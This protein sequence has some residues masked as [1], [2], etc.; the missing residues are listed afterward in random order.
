[1]PRFLILPVALAICACSLVTQA[2]TVHDIQFTTDPAGNSPYAGQQVGT[3]GIVTGVDFTGQPIRY[4]VSDRGGGL[5]SGVL[6]N[7]NQDRQVEI[8]DSVSFT[9]EVQE[10]SGQTRLR[11]IVVGS[12]ALVPAQA[13]VPS[14]GVA[15]A[16]VAESTEGVLIELT[17]AVVVSANSDSTF[18]VT[19]GTGN[20]T[21]ARGWYSTYFPIVGDTLRFLRGIVSYANQFAVN[22]RSD[23]DLGFFGNR[24]PIILN[25]VNTPSD[26]TELQSDTVTAL[27]TD[28]GF[29]ADAHLHYR[30]GAGE[31]LDVELTDD[32]TRADRLAGDHVYSGVIPAGP[33]R[34]VCQYF[35]HATDNDA[36]ESYSP[37][38]AP[39]ITYSYRVR[40]A[41]LTIFDLQYT[42]D[43]TGGITPYDGQTVTV[44]GIVTGT[45][46]GS[47]ASDFF[48]SDPLSM[49]PDSGRWSGV[50]VYGAN[51]T[52]ALWDS[53]TI[54]GQ[55]VDYSGSLT[56]FTSGG[57]VT[58]LGTG[59]EIPPLRVRPAQLSPPNS[60]SPDS[61]EA[62]EGVLVEIGV[63]VVTNTDDYST[64]QQFDVSGPEGSCTIINDYGFEYTPIE[65]DSFRFIRGNVSF[66]PPASFLGHII[67]PRFDADLDYIDHRPPEV[68]GA[69]AVSD[70]GVN[71]EFNERISGLGLND[72]TNYQVIDQSDP[73]HPEIAVS[74][75]YVF[76]TGKTLHLDLA[77]PLIPDHGYRLEIGIV[78]DASD[79]I[80]QNGVVFF[81][82]YEETPFTPISVL[83]DSFDVYDGVIVTLRGVVNFM[84][85][86]TTTSG[87]RRI[88]AYMQDNSGYGFS[89]SQTGA[90]ATFPGIRRGNFIEITGIVNQFGGTIQL[91]SF[92]GTSDVRVLAENVPLP[93]PIE[94][95]TGDYRRQAQIVRTS[96]EGYYGAGTW[97]EVS[98]TV[99]RVDENVG[100]GTNM[101]FDDGTGNIVIRIWDSMLLDSVRL[102]GRWYK[103][104]D[105]PGV[106]CSIAGPSSTYNGDF[107]ML[108]GY[109]Q[110][111]TTDLPDILP[112][113]A[114]K[115]EIAN[116]PFGRNRP[117][118]PD[119]G[120]SLSIFYNAPASGSVRL[121][122]FDL[123]GH[124]VTTL[125]DK[126]AGGPNTVVWNGRN[127]LRELVPLG[128]YILHLESVRNG[129]SK[130]EVKPVVVGTKL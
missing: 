79:N 115:L 123:R 28:D 96:H 114:L 30:F 43:P 52:P 13:A 4:F 76:S 26:P 127:D 31:F 55:I 65:G 46:Y 62:Y 69:T 50:L 37:A 32:G 57:Q 83:Y 104:R 64:F 111:F 80:L 36:G 77:Q 58:V 116:E 84:Q 95:R 117:F 56:E 92:N 82:G 5:W 91:G 87:S 42:G 39:D 112:S 101:Y 121:R 110:D 128:T 61:G 122:I 66:I 124:L 113:E 54:T 18:V 75:G 60:S 25:V 20:A 59:Q 103:L 78:Y 100:G 107:Q 51:L 118:A 105:L 48:I 90:A 108:A 10:S 73:E 16:D 120:Q 126:G 47:N 94:V 109:A 49:L 99:Y 19:D 53:V 67:A 45:N 44:T 63:C 129:D 14:I 74:G 130:S 119:I 40:G 93:A 17:D 9:A 98:G 8:G 71:I 21:I 33:A 1:M 15:C 3:G 23:A 24:P 29:V 41:S 97:V 89:L 22:P 2:V 6:V 70:Y 34:A 38:G 81:G 27:I 86:V 102:N 106:T 85:D 35:V 72:P 68:T 11:N 88:S 12:F 7:D 125:V